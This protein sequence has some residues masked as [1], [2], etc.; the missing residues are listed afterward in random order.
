MS[1][2]PKHDIEYS[3]KAAIGSVKTYCELCEVAEVLDVHKS[4]RARITE[5]EA[6]RW[7]C[8]RHAEHFEQEVNHHA[9]CPWC[10]LEQAEAERDFHI[11]SVEHHVEKA[12]SEIERLE[13]ENERLKEALKGMYLLYNEGPMIAPENANE[14]AKQALQGGGER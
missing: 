4:C 5:L 2:C 3:T 8:I 13:A 10:A 12:R 14:T 9:K 7:Y 1:R 6:S 11:K